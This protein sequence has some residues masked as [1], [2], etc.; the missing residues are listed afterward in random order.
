MR[1]R[2]PPSA[3]P[4]IDGSCC[5]PLPYPSPKSPRL[6]NSSPVLKFLSMMFNLL[7]LI[8]FLWPP[9][10]PNPCRGPIHWTF[11]DGPGA[12]SAPHLLESLR[13]RNL[14]GTWFVLGSQLWGK[15]KI[16][17][18]KR[19]AREGHRVAN[20]LY[21]HKSPCKLGK[22]GVRKELLQTEWLLRHHTPHAFKQWYRPPYG[23]RCHW[24]VPLYRGYTTIMWNV[25]DLGV[26]AKRMWYLIKRRS[27][28]GK[29]TVVLVHHNWRKF[30]R[31]LQLAEREG[32][33][34]DYQ[35]NS[36]SRERNW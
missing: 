34:N 15:H 5:G 6:S 10:V 17:L 31:L 18:L 14:K 24:R 13:K 9:F 3:K 35:R 28:Q 26:S 22:H 33:F 21:T 36:A 12:Y 4:K 16:R 27:Q 30:E 1:V 25:A 23:S 7:P 8:L 2:V 29:H 32:C 11:D 19:I 20:H